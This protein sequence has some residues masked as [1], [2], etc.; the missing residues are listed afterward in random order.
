M[1][2]C[3]LP[4]VLHVTPPAATVSWAVRPSPAIG[5]AAGVEV[6]L[7][8]ADATWIYNPPSVTRTTAG[9]PT[10]EAFRGAAASRA[11]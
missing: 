9:Q 8:L 10:L 4:E 2:P 7:N 5:W 1:T 6:A 11:G 3:N